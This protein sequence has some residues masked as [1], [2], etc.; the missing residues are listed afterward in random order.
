MQGAT[1]SIAAKSGRIL[2]I[3]GSISPLSEAFLA[4]QVTIE[5]CGIRIG[6]SVYTSV[7][8][9]DSASGQPAVAV[10]AFA[11][12]PPIPSCPYIVSQ[13][14][15]AIRSIAQLTL[16]GSRTEHLVP[17]VHRECAPGSIRYPAPE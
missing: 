12:G 16:D 13:D 4:E 10:D 15:G 5:I 14:P 1:G 6:V 7:L 2:A 3:V 8:S 17:S 11:E 9:L